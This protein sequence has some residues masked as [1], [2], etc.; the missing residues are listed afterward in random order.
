MAGVFI[1]YLA[2]ITLIAGN[3]SL[4]HQNVN[5]EVEGVSNA[6][7]MSIVQIFQHLFVFLTT[8]VL[9]QK[10]V[11]VIVFQQLKSAVEG[12][13]SNVLM[14]QTV[15]LEKSPNAHLAHVSSAQKIV[16]ALALRRHQCVAIL[17]EGN[18]CNAKIIQ[19]ALV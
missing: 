11:T 14:I 17:Q 13:V 19:T 7:I 16:N 6:T 9:V 10:T 15:R 12:H 5:L 3:G 18:V 2:R 4:I 1:A 8:V